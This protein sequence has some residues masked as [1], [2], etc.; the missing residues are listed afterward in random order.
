MA[1][2]LHTLFNPRAVAFVGV[3]PDPMKYAGRALA[4]LRQGGF[5]GRIFA[6]NPKYRSAWRALR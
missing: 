3:S 2:D 6:V 1:N 4:I 5:S